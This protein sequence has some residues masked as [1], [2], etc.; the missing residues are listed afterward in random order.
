MLFAVSSNSKSDKIVDFA[1]VKAK[2]HIR[3]DL[4]HA[5]HIVAHNVV[6]A[7]VRVDKALHGNALLYLIKTLMQT[8][9]FAIICLCRS[10]LVPLLECKRV[11]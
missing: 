6:E 11:I 2:N 9:H 5:V 7:S 4:V 3:I 1:T 8:A 10:R